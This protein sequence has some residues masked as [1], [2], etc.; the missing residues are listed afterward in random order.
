MKRVCFSDL[1]HAEKLEHCIGLLKAKYGYRFE[2]SHPHVS[3]MMLELELHNPLIKNV[4]ESESKLFAHPYKNP[5]KGRE[6][7]SHCS[8]IIDIDIV[9]GN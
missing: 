2:K 1:S 8:E 7:F 4:E 5:Y 9:Y 6:Y 3:E